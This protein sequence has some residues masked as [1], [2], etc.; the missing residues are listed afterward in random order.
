MAA[1]REPRLLSDIVVFLMVPLAVWV[2]F[3]VGGRGY[4]GCTTGFIPRT[5]SPDQER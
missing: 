3:K 2:D 5:N 4:G 1:S